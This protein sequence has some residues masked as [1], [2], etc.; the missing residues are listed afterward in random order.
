M[1]IARLRAEAPSWTWSYDR[2]DETYTGARGDSRVK[3]FPVSVLSGYTGDDFE[4]QWR[5][6][7]G[8]AAVTYPRWWL[9]QQAGP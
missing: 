7:D 1:N 4:T 5:V 2:S 6:D 9:L 3:V 8:S